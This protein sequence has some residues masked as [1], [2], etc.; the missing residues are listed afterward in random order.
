[1]NFALRKKIEEAISNPNLLKIAN[2]SE[3]YFQKAKDAL[4]HFL[5]LEVNDES[6]NLLIARK[7]DYHELKK[8]LENSQDILSF[9]NAIFSVISYCDAK[10]HRKNEFNE[11]E[12]TRVLALAFVRM[13]N[14]VEQLITYKF[15]KVLVDGSVKNAVEYLLNPIDHFTMLSENHRSQISQNLFMKPFNGVTFKN[16][17]IEFFSELT[18]TVNNTENYTHFLTRICYAIEKEWKDSVIGLVCPDSTG[19]QEDA[20]SDSENGKPIVLWNHKKP[21]GTS[22]TL[23]LLKQ[24]I[25]EDGFFR[26]FYTSKHEVKYI[27]EIIDFA[28]NQQEL[29]KATWSNLYGQINWYQ[30]KFSD[31]SDGN[32]SASWVYLARKIES[33]NPE[34]YQDFKYYKSSYPSVGNQSPVVSYKCYREVNYQNQMNKIIN[35]LSYKKQIILQGP[36]GTG[37]TRLAKE[38]AVDLVKDTLEYSS[39]DDAFITANLQIGLSIPTPD[40]SSS[41]KILNI[42]ANTVKVQI[43]T[44]GP[45]SVT[46]DKIR[47]VVKEKSSNP[48]TYANGMAIFLKKRLAESAYKIVQFH[49]SY[50]YEDFVRGIVAESRGDKIEYKSVNKCI[51]LFAEE[52]LKSFLD[53]KKTPELISKE[54]WVGTEYK[55]FK[56]ILELEL[57][58]H[59]EILIKSETKPKIIAI[60]DKSIRVNR[61]SNEK[62]SVLIKDNDIINGYIGLYLSTPSI[63]IKD[64]KALS[65]SARSGMYY[66]YQNLIE[67]FK[68]HLTENKQSFDP[69]TIGERQALKSYTLI[70]DEINRANLSSV[71]GELIYALEYRGEEVEAVYEVDGS[72]KLVLPPN[73][74]I[75]GTMNT[76]D[77]SVGH[78]DYAIRRRFAFVEV[79][80]KNLQQELGDDF[81]SEIFNVV[82]GLF[83]KNFN[84]EMDYSANAIAIEKSD[85]LNTDFDPKDVWLG[86]SYFIQ[87]YEKDE[88]G[89]NIKE[90]PIDFSL[91]IQYEIKPILEEYIKDGILKESAKAIIDQL[92]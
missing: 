21:V 17:F 18:L 73:L 28:E 1:M 2:S 15:E 14:W 25:E 60:E 86:H 39:L 89:N 42:E 51:G 64:N 52:A 87:Q 45:Y 46:F 44:G 7:K 6:K 29:D 69:K 84:P 74:Y 23:K 78:I 16:D 81:K 59:G 57:E 35:L 38:M 77:R 37:K 79:L 53:F 34:D 32:K 92:S 12:D 20:I 31:Y 49:P 63:K 76:A 83:V 58:K 75:I 13:N 43:N 19:W 80:P 50:T 41:F 62:D 4:Q 3:F 68:S 26:V 36:P 72:N 10:A 65:K 40:G 9:G 5:Q 82:A 61:Y 56:E 27:A 30:E 91:R 71:L 70:I 48:D 55:K 54:I 47:T 24:C 11:Y 8:L 22:S 33:V 90:K 88:N 66:L 67:K 85:Y